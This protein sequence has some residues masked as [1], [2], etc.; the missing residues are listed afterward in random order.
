MVTGMFSVMCLSALAQR[1]VRGWPSVVFIDSVKKNRPVQDEPWLIGRTD[2]V[3]QPQDP[4][5]HAG[6]QSLFAA[7]NGLFLC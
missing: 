1:S 5:G 7:F 4:V 2:S 6:M 3:E